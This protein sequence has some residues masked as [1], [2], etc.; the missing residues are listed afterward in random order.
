[1]AR[2]KKKAVVQTTPQRTR[3]LW[4]KAKGYGFGWAPARWEGW[5]VLGTYIVV[6]VLNFLR[7]DG[8]SHSVSDT[9]TSFIPE[10]FV[11]TFILFYIC[12]KT[13]EAPKWKWG[14]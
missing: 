1:M 12:V 2:K 4:F 14:S 11:L 10:T 7:I 9:M 13:G 6:V 8:Q 5:V 3:K